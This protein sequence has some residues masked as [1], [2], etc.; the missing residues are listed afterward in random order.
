MSNTASEPQIVT[1]AP[2]SRQILEVLDFQPMFARHINWDS[3]AERAR[4]CGAS[5]EARWTD[6]GACM[7]TL[8]WAYTADELR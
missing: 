6:R 1:T 5:F 2:E 4:E 3:I 7:V 8:F